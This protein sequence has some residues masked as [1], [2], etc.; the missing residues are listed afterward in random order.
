MTG[1]LLTLT[2]LKKRRKN[3]NPFECD[4]VSVI[5]ILPTQNHVRKGVCFFFNI[6]KSCLYLNVFLVMVLFSRDV[7]DG[8]HL[9]KGWSNTG[10]AE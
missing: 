2:K 5:L 8:V 1:F 3:R 9:D 6:K 4:V 10:E 7:K